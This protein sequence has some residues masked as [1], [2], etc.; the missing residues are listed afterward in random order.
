MGSNVG[1]EIAVDGYLAS[2]GPVLENVKG[3]LKS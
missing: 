2:G 1:S 3:I